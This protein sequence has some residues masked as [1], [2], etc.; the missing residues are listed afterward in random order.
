MIGQVGNLQLHRQEAEEQDADGLAQK[1]SEEH[2]EEHR[3]RDH[4]ENIA[5]KEAHI[6]VGQREQG[7]HSKVHPRVQHMLQARGRGYHLTSNTGEPGDGEHVILL[8]RHRLGLHIGGARLAN[9]VARPGHEL[10]QIDARPRGDREGEQHASDG[11][12]N[13][14]H[15]HSE[16]QQATHQ[17]VRRQGVHVRPVHQYEHHENGRSNGKP[18]ER[19][20]LA[21]EDGNDENGDDVV[22]HGQGG[23]EHAHAV[24][25]AV[26]EQ[27]HDAQGEGDIGRRRHA[28][29]VG[30]LRVGGVE[31]GVDDDRG[32]NA[33][34]GRDDG[35]RRLTDVRELADGHLVFDL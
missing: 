10:L 15:E 1:Q 27:R 32:Q 30:G 16:P 21:V 18:H 11:G 9:P 31:D 5:A 20:A 4:S 34:A 17:H 29:A 22:G 35:Q 33:A 19:G 28:P 3:A 14:G 23:E 26:A 7:Q 13:T 6:G 24:G 8:K 25:H 12:M 2:A